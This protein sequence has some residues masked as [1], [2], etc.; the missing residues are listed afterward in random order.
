MDALK[1]GAPLLVTVGVATLAPGSL[2]R[3]RL[4]RAIGEAGQRG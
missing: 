1:L 2:G 4:A 3:R